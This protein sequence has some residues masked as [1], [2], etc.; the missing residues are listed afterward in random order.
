MANV[1]AEQSDSWTL[2]QVLEYL[3]AHGGTLVCK[4]GTLAVDFPKSKRRKLILAAVLPHLTLRK[5]ELVAH[6]ERT[7][8]EFL[9]PVS[10]EQER[11]RVIRETMA[12]AAA[13]GRVLYYLDRHGRAIPDN[14]KGVR[15][16]FHRRGRRYKVPLWRYALYVCVAGDDS[17]TKLPKITTREEDDAIRPPPRP[18]W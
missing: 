9:K 5:P 1:Q 10:P 15:R 17:W 3:E 7:R 18:K 2:E 8:P 14:A 12:R 6:L 13:T 4:G 11:K 16:I